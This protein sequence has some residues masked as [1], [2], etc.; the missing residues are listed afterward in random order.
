MIEVKCKAADLLP[1]DRIL[2]FQGEL[3]KLSK[4]NKDKL[5]ASILKH[6]FIA[7]MFVWDNSGDYSLLDGHQ[8][9][10]TLISMRQEGYDIPLLPVV[11]VEADNEEDAKE[12]LLQITSKYGEFTTKGFSDFTDGLDFDIEDF[13]IDVPMEKEEIE[14]DVEFSEELMEEHNYIVLYFSNNIDWLNAK[15]FFDLETVSSMR[16]NGKPW[17]KGIGRVVDGVKYIRKMQ[18]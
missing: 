2:E 13:N 10:S 4:K 16:S 18:E 7:P 8:R 3:K 12:K 14:G 17:S 5:K 6:G 9:L 1:I 11:Y 15:T